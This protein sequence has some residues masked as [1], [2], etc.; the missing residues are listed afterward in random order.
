MHKGSTMVRLEAVS[1]G[2]GKR[3]NRVN[4]LDEVTVDFPEGVFTAVMGPSGSGKSTLLQCAAGIDRVD[5]GEVELAGAKLA[6]LSEAALTRLRRQHVGFVFQ[7]FNL[8]PSLT[9]RQN[10]AL[11][12]M[13]AGKKPRRKDVD[14]ALDRLGLSERKGHRPGEMSGGQQQRV[15]IA[16][17][18]LTRPKV[19]FADEPTGA[20]DSKSSRQVME[21][22]REL[23]DRD[24]QTIIM[25]THDPVAASVSDRIVFLADGKLA[26]WLESPTPELA[27]ER[28]T[29]LE[30]SW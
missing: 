6:G 14:G 2:F 18:L 27:A 3:D 23:V 16:R 12:L 15:A 30:Q 28:I 17:A 1:R 5:S 20:L 19:L 26:G 13:L 22:L 29:K 21:Q 24:G 10:V 9:A 8:I 25:V 7:T 4:A 11:P